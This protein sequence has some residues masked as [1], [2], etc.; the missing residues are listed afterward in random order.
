M[1]HQEPQQRVQLDCLALLS[2]Q[3]LLLR[4]LF[5]AIW[6]RQAWPRQ[7]MGSDQWQRLAELVAT[8]PDDVEQ[9]TQ[10]FPGQVTAKKAGE[11][12]WL[13]RPPEEH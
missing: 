12:L 6:K 13:T 10:C 7:A 3:D 4:E 9:M 8:A 5:V 1:F 2:S 11:S